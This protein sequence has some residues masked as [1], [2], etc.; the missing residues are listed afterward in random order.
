MNKETN[1][2]RLFFL[3]INICIAIIGSVRIFYATNWGPWAFS[4]SA[5][6]FSAARNL[7]Q[8]HGMILKNVDGSIDYYQLFPPLYPIVLGITGWILNNFFTAARWI[9]VL[10]FGLF[11]FLSGLLLFNQT[12]KPVISL[13]G[14]AI[15]LVSPMMVTDFTGAMTE[16]IFLVLM[17][18]SFILILSLIKKPSIFHT[19]A[20]ILATALLPVTR[21]VGIG[22]IFINFIILLFFIQKP[23]K[24]R[25]LFSSTI[26]LIS[27]T[28]ILAWFIYLFTLTNRIGG[29]GFRIKGSLINN[30]INGLKT[31]YDIFKGFLPYD[32]LYEGIISSSIRLN[33]LI[34]A[35]LLLIA[36]SIFCL[37]KQPVDKKADGSNFK[38]HI[39]FP[40]YIIAFIIFIGFSYSITNRS[41]VIDHRQISPLIPMIIITSLYSFSILITNL[42]FLRTPLTIIAVGLFA[43]IFRYYFFSSRNLVRSLYE[44]GYG[45]TARQYQESGIIEAVKQIPINREIISNV[46]GFILLYDNRLPIEPVQFEFHMYGSGDGYGEATFRNHQAALVLLIPDFNNYYGQQAAELYSVLTKGLNVAF[47]DSVSAIYYYPK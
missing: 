35:F 24:N 29:R 16:P 34:A 40:M 41:Y 21:Y 42:K 17:I 45:Y 15:L 20:F 10:A 33:L 46:S 2:V 4:D 32:G 38:N 8:G 1:K 37:I 7:V 11:L 19:L 47:Q 5:S 13:M 6:Y 31:V 23:I 14:P 27:S 39:I 36:A 9:N 26:T 3:T 22:F 28:P 25:F 30:F 44:N 18:L 12:K 43:Y